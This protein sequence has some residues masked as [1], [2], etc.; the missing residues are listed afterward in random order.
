MISHSLL[1]RFES[2]VVERKSRIVAVVVVELGPL[3][4][5]LEQIGTS[6]IESV[7]PVGTSTD[8]AAA[9]HIHTVS[10]HESHCPKS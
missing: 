10:F 3:V 5:Q 1:E 4:E 8:S 9:V 2:V 6:M 7:E